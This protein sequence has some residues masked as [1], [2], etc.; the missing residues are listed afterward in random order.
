MALVTTFATGPLVERP[1][2][3]RQAARARWARP[4]PVSA[5]E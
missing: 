4:V 1:T 3:R 5:R 2:R